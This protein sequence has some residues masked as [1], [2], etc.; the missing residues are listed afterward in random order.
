MAIHGVDLIR[1]EKYI[2]NH[3]PSVVF[4]HMTGGFSFAPVA[5]PEEAQVLSTCQCGFNSHRGYQRCMMERN[6]CCAKNAVPAKAWEFESP[7][8]D[9][10][11]WRKWYTHQSQK[12]TRETL[13]GFD[14]RHL[15]LLC[16][17]EGN[18][19]TSSAQN[20][21]TASSNLAP[22]INGGYANRL[23]Q[24]VCKTVTHGV[25]TAGSNP[26]PPICEILLR[27]ERENNA[28]H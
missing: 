9:I 21:R 10:Q 18:R 27:K 4:Y 7:C 2:A 13:Y 15:Y 23:K 26:A 24:A 14:P 12:L 5:Q 11:M 22:G 20:R 3:L 19:N 1:S 6:T 28:G 16:P 8:T 25:N 17:D